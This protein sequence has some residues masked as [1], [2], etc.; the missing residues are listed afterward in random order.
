VSIFCSACETIHSLEK[1]S[2]GQNHPT[3]GREGLRCGSGSP[4]GGR[5]EY[6]QYIRDD[7]FETRVVRSA[8]ASSAEESGVGVARKVRWAIFFP[9]PGWHGLVCV[10][11]LITRPEGFVCVC[12]CVCVLLVLPGTTPD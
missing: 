2:T 1:E 11:V 10:L 6:L 7:L 12:D 8:M 3:G 5:I 9:T 4:D